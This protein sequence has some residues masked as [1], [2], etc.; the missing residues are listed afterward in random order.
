MK[1]FIKENVSLVI[2]L[3]LPVAFAMF[4]FLSKNVSQ[5]NIEPPKHDFIIWDM[6]KNNFEILVVNEKLKAN[7]IYPKNVQNNN[8]YVRQPK[9]FYVDADTL[10]A[11]PIH[12]E[13]PRDAN[14]PSE[15]KEGLR[16]AIETTQFEDLKFSS[17]LISPDGFELTRNDYRDG[18][19][20][21]EIFS[22]HRRNKRAMVLRKDSASFEIKGLENVYGFRVIGWV[23]DIEQ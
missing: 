11:E 8:F 14:A 18:N 23:K 17:S 19:I 1:S 2:A 20:M 5:H 9:V 6:R 7:F 4:F 12:F 3:A 15:E 10:I 13:L 16:T 21:T 22:G